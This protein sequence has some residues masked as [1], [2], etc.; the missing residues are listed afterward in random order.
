MARTAS[1]L[2]LEEYDL[3]YGHES[4][5]EYWFGEA[6]RKPAPTYLHGL[7][8]LLLAEL[9]RK[10]G[11]FVSG[12]SD[13]KVVSD[14][15]PRPD[16]YGVIEGVEGTYATKVDVVFEVLS[17]DDDILAKCQQYAR[18]GIPQVFAFDPETQTITEWAND[19]LMPVADVRLTNGV[20]ITG[21]TIWREMLSRQR[22]RLEP[23]P[24]KVI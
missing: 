6:R 24:S 4:G 10:A 13:L 18:I 11:Y 20:T 7:L 15:Q 9:L 8:S 2:S 12:E 21:Q 14:W 5:W 22:E 16:V 1:S 3:I 19:R 23:P 17:K